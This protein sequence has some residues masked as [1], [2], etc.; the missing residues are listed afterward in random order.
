MM[1]KFLVSII[2]LLFA[3][4]DLTGAVVNAPFASERSK[5]RASI[6][7]PFDCDLGTAR[8]LTFRFKCQEMGAFRG[9]SCYVR[10]D[11]QWFHAPFAPSVSASWQTVKLNKERFTPEGGKA[12]SWSKADMVRISGWRGGDINSSFSI[13]SLAA[14]K[15]RPLTIVLQAQS[16]VARRGSGGDEVKYAN[17]MC[18]SLDALGFEPLLLDDVQ[19]DDSLL[20]G[21]NLLALPLNPSIPPK[22]MSV[23]K[24]FVA[25]GGR[26]LVCY[27]PAPGI[28][29]LMGI[30]KGAIERPLGGFSGFES[31]NG[32]LAGQPRFAPQASWASVSVKPVAANGRIVARWRTFNGKPT[33]L[34]AAV[35]TDRGV[36]LGH[37][38]MG[39]EGQSS[40]FLR[41]MCVYCDARLGERAVAAEMCRVGLSSLPSSM[42]K[43]GWKK[44]LDYVR[45]RSNDALM[46]RARKFAPTVKKK[47][48][49]RGYWCHSAWGVPGE[50]W[51]QTASRLSKAGINN[52]FV[53]IAWGG[54]AYHK[55]KVLP[56]A[57]SAVKNGSPVQDCINACRKHG[58]AFHAWKV[59]FNGSNGATPRSW[60]EAMRKQKRF[61]VDFKGVEKKGWLCPSHPDN[62]RMEVQAAL[63]MAAIPG[64]SGV[65]LDYIRYSSADYC[66]CQ[67]CRKRFETAQGKKVARW[68]ADVLPRGCDRGKWEIFRRNNIS[69]VVKRISNGLKTQK[70]NVKFS[71]AV[72][73]NHRSCRNSIGQDWQTWCRMGWVDFV[74]P[75]DYLDSAQLL[76]STLAMQKPAV[77]GTRAKMY[78]GLGYSVWKGQDRQEQLF[79]QLRAVVKADLDGFLI[80]NLDATSSAAMPLLEALSQ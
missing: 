74:C 4:S 53:N 35:A 79:E 56:M 72:F 77:A 50:N 75:M 30:K 42:K 41:S 38:W 47:L 1:G 14:V 59:C 64:S 45:A 78:P 7:L 34:P 43:A 73:D 69:D 52:L 32:G 23:I 67:G 44:R 51:E 22:A 31:V 9:F 17:I 25:R 24:R 19:L 49:F 16:V 65:H 80:Y 40:D 76:S 71:A 46:Q 55:S 28:C 60:T 20:T 13:D 33:S 61:T 21:V 27:L 10:S 54:V 66:F 57:E 68:P 62:R 63:E 37:V 3:S 29:E 26:L 48:P 15:N 36:F 6:D 5:E 2:F 70:L 18:R 12:I 39:A 11:G 8:G 58:I